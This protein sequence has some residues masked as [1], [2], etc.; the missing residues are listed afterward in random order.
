MN[1]ETTTTTTAPDV[2]E[3]VVKMGNILDD[4]DRTLSDPG[5][6]LKGCPSKRASL[7]YMHKEYT[8]LNE[9]LNNIIHET[10][11]SHEQE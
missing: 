9:Q 6:T 2:N 1:T 10:L 8:G 5:F 4:I 11:M 3:L 7:Y